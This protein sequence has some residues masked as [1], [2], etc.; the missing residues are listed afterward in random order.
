M[1]PAKRIMDIVLA[2]VIGLLALVPFGVIVVLLLREGGPVFY[3]SERMR[4]PGQA[5]R[6]FKFRTMRGA[7]QNGGVS[8]GDK[9]ARITPLGRMLRRARLD[10]IPQ[11]WNILRGDMSFVGPRPPLRIYVERFPDLYAQV[12]RSRPGVTGLAS[13]HFHGHEERLLAACKTADETDAV[14]ARRCIPRKARL[15][16]IYQRRRTLCL[17]IAIVGQ[18]FGRV[19]VSRLFRR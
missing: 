15:D 16:L 9:L 10:E 17:D 14:Y 13:L 11:L 6:L 1:T 19:I 12:L 18:T 4:A 3:V 5:F 7:V 2:L 8:G